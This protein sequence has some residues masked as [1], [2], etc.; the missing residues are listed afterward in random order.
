MC[1][2]CKWERATR[3]VCEKRQTGAQSTCEC[4]GELLVYTAR[5]NKK[6]NPRCSW[7][8]SWPLFLLA[9]TLSPPPIIS[10]PPDVLA[11]SISLP[12]SPNPP[13]K[14]PPHPLSCPELCRSFK[15][16]RSVWVRSSWLPHSWSFLSVPTPVLFYHCLS[17]LRTLTLSSHY[18]THF[19]FSSPHFLHS[20]TISSCSWM[21]YW[22]GF[23][24]PFTHI[25]FSPSLYSFCSPVYCNAQTSLMCVRVSIQL[26]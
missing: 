17:F 21:P 23:L 1:D 6:R 11:T 26:Y 22:L 25:L 7:M 8:P 24:F 9:I 10:L 2:M 5:E 19:F 4:W 12:P 13:R 15:A 14:T 16:E 3:T 18:L 20:F